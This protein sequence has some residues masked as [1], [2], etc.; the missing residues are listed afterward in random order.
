MLKNEFRNAI[1]YLNKKSKTSI[2]GLLV[3]KLQSIAT[4]FHLPTPVKYLAMY[5]AALA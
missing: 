1:F 3:K 5:C 4:P 2:S